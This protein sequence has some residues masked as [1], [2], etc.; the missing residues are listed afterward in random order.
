MERSWRRALGLVARAM[1][2]WLFLWSGLF[3][4]LPGFAS[5]VRM[6]A[7]RGLP[8]PAVLAVGAGIVEIGAPLALF[9]RSTEAPAGLL[10]AIYCLLTAT[11]FHPYW[12][13]EPGQ[14]FD[15]QVHFLKDIALSGAFLL[16]FLQSIDRRPA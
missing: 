13:V 9:F 11:L 5:V 4:I 3:G 15:V 7:D 6:I 10:L 2:A 12:E 8:A 1:L 16:L 14:R